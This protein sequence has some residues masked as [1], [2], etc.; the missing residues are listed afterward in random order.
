MSC[1]LTNGACERIYLVLLNAC[2]LRIGEK[3]REK[4]NGPK[5]EENKCIFWCGM[6]IKKN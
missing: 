1:F 6:N 3:M 2:I 4:E 5:R